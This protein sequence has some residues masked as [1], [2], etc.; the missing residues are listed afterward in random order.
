MSSANKAKGTRFESEIVDLLAE[1]FEAQRLPRTGVKDE[2]DVEVRF[3]SFRL[4]IEAKNHKG[5]SLA[6]WIKQ[7]EVEAN[8]REAKLKDTACVP[9]VF[10]KR[11]GKGVA[12]SYVVMDA[13]EF[14]LLLKLAGL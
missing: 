7:A 14:M 13:T 5:L 1:Q 12:N 4:V 6:D 2:G 3:K 9:V 10:A 11:R 8:N